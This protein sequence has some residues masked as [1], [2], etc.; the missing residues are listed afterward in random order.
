VKITEFNYANTSVKELTG[1]QIFS[2]VPGL[3]KTWRSLL[4]GEAELN[5]RER[6]GN[7]FPADAGFVCDKAFAKAAA[8]RAKI[9]ETIFM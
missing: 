9:T 8:L 5:C 1:K 4:P 6:T 2:E 3:L 7:T